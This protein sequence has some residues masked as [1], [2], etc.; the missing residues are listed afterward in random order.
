MI[1]EFYHGYMTLERLADLMGSTSFGITAYQL[2]ETAKKIGFQAYG[3]ELY[4][5]GEKLFHLPAIA[6]IQSTEG[7]YHYV[8]IY[9]IHSKQETILI[10]DPAKGIDTLTFAEFQQLWTN[11]ICIFYPVR[12]LPILDEKYT[13]KDFI[14]PIIKPHYHLLGKIMLLSIIYGIFSMI[15]N[16]YVTIMVDTIPEQSKSLVWIV[17]GIMVIVYILKNITD[18]FRNRL[19]L[20]FHERIN[21]FFTLDILKRLIFLPYKYYQNR[22]TGEVIS[23]LNELMYLQSYIEKCCVFLSFD[24][25]LFLISF[26]ILFQINSTLLFFNIIILLLDLLLWCF[27]KRSYMHNQYQLQV[28]KAVVNQTLT[29]SLM[30]FESIK[31]LHLEKNILARTSN[32]YL[33]YIKEDI[34][35]QL[36]CFRHQLFRLNL[37]DMTYTISIFS[38]AN[39]IMEG[40][41]T[42]GEMIAFQTFI[43]Y[44]MMAVT[45][46]SELILSYR[47]VIVA[48]EQLNFLF[49]KGKNEVSLPRLIKGEIVLQHF[50]YELEQ[51][52]ILFDDCSITIM[53][54]YKV[55]LLGSSGSGKSTLMK[56]LMKYYKTNRGQ[57]LIDGI[58]LL[59][60][61]VETLQ[62]YII[63]MNQFGTL[64]TDTLYYNIVLNRKVDTSLLDEILKICAVDKILEQRGTDLSMRVEENGMNLSGGERQ[65]ILLARALLSSFQILL[66]DEGLSQV[67]R[68]LEE[69][70]LRRLFLKYHNKTIILVSHR[71]EYSVLFHQVL[72]IKNRKIEVI[73]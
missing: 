56:I 46:T 39:M 13:L 73:T 33:R 23:K 61:Q 72:E 68:M 18:Y 8:V 66:I 52:G 15:T 22:T 65:R 60:Y 6:H 47:Q 25:I 32:H 14:L 27:L 7:Y 36:L 51:G 9:E 4:E 41:S 21:L 29:E 16:F 71:R 20:L 50:Y 70:I 28:S 44:F 40:S 2:I 12:T 38:L 17:L 42:I 53:P 58:D 10:A 43:S 45:K 31:G 37:H 3:I 64:F 48:V 19:L 63:Y 55:L 35:Y 62:N 34:R 59:D 30:S 1:I 11:V 69:Q 26:Y 67:D 57:V 24:C 49:Q 5:I 54:H